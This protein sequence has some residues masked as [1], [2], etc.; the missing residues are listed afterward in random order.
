MS[1]KSTRKVIYGDDP[2][3]IRSLRP[4][5]VEP[6]RLNGGTHYLY[7]TLGEGA[8]IGPV[9]TS[10]D[11]TVGFSSLLLTS[12]SIAIVAALILTLAYM[13]LRKLQS[14]VAA[15]SHDLRGPLSSVQGYLETLLQR[16]DSLDKADSKRFMNVALR[17]TQSAATMVDDLHH[18]SK[19]EASGESPPME[20]FSLNDLL[21]DVTL[22][23]TPEAEERGIKL[24][25]DAPAS[26]P[27]THGNIQLIERLLRNLVQN[28]LRYTPRGGRIDVT[29]QIVL[30][31]VR[32]SVADSGCGIPA[33]ELE[34]VTS[35][36][37]RA[38]NIKK[39]VAGSGIGL[40]IASSIARIHGS[41]LKILSREGQGTVVICE[42]SQA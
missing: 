1:D 20:S 32:V 25:L 14:G 10:I 33:N 31:R 42:L 21:M 22:S 23:A 18:L 35:P 4:I 7:V 8:H 29:A 13:R 24:S 30:N 15:L 27:L 26:L 12:I 41:E 17:S 38:K 40:S 39:K 5:S 36:F 2:L 34:K 37:F 11:G 9:E 3:K 16:G 19:I 28:S 6:L